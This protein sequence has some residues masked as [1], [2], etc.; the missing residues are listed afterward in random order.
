MTIAAATTAP[1]SN[2]PVAAAGNGGGSGE[3][4]DDDVVPTTAEAKAK[5]QTIEVVTEHCSTKTY[6]VTACDGTLDDDDDDGEDCTV[7]MMK[8]RVVTLQ[9]LQTI[10]VTAVPDAVAQEG[11][12]AVPV[13]L[14]VPMPTLSP[15][16]TELTQA[17]ATAPA[18]EVVA[19]E[20]VRGGTAEVEAE[21]EALTTIWSTVVVSPSPAVGVGAVSAAAGGYSWSVSNGSSTAGVVN[22]VACGATCGG[23]SVVPTGGVAVVA[24]AEGRRRGLLGL[25]GRMA[26]LG[27]GIVL[28]AV[29]L[30]WSL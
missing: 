1:A 16:T 14:P 4:D 21:T 9:A 28:G 22:G 24:G 27:Y 15:M 25:D 13:S 3:D 29:V 8:T 18:V 2:P 11:G 23:V 10:V 6:T 5:I 20:T 7:G 12:G 19:V 26:L 30:G 17:M